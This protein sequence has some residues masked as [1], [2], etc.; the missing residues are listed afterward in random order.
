M[1]EQAV[2]DNCGRG[3]GAIGGGCDVGKAGGVEL[4]SETAGCGI[5]A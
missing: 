3:G 2:V 4:P 5:V 1:T